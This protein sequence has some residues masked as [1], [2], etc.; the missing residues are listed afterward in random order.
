[1][2]RLLRYQH[3]AL[4]LFTIAAIL[5]TTRAWAQSPAVL[6]PAD[7]PVY[8]HINKPAEWFGDMTQG[9]L[10]EKFR[11]EVETAEGSGDLLAAMG[12]DLDAFLAAYFGGDV[13]VLSPGGDKSGVIFTQVSQANRNHAIDTL[14]LKQNGDIAGHPIYVGPDGNGYFV[15]M[16][17]WVAMC[18]LSAVDYLTSV[19]KQG[20]DAPRLADTA[21]YAKWTAELPADRSMTALVYESEESQH[22]M[23]VVRSG[24]G[25]DATYLGT[26]PDFAPLM[27]MLGQTNVADFG[28]LPSNTIAA[29]SFNIVAS[30]DVQQQ[31]QG[32]DML[33]A[34]KSFTKDVLPKLDAPTLMF[35]GSVPGNEV[36]PKVDVDVPVVGLAMKMNDASVAEDLSRLFDNVVLIGNISVAQ[37]QAGAI[38]QRTQ[39]YKESTFKV[40]E[41]GKPVAQGLEFPELAP[42]QIVY[43]QVGEYFIVCTQEQYFKKCI[44]ANAGGKPMRMNV[45]GPA[46]RLAKTPVLA[47]T[48]RPDSFGQLLLSWGK[49]LEA[50][51]LPEAIAGE[52][53]APAD[54][55]MLFDV[56][57]MLQQYSL[58]KVQVWTG[59]D[60][61]I[62]GRAQLTAPQ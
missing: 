8:I 54:L 29:M 31:F 62:I 49:M 4:T 9:P 32:L 2:T 46:H 23:G 21:R 41:I 45:E 36:E 25:L 17:D 43:G 57:T 15:M 44:D 34:G 47:M 42:I 28:P 18:D 27:G 53:E 26:S 55:D 13:V 1:M 10:G 7:T 16:D 14:E 33:L 3:L 52:G 38:P 12:M 19:L 37:F 56:V 39:T 59:D 61:L 50:K 35:M 30:E 11:N 51:G 6:A 40:A 58:A 20:K 22:A 5:L 24:K 60:G 48:A